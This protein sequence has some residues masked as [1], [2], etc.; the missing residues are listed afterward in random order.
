MTILAIYTPVTVARGEVV[1]NGENP[2]SNLLQVL[3]IRYPINFKKKSMSVL[4]DLG[5][6]VN[7]VHLIFAKE[8][9]LSIRSTG[10][11]AQKIYG[12][13]VDTYGMIVAAFSVI[14]KANQVKFF[15]ETFL[16]ANV[17]TK[18]VLKILFFTLTSVDVDFLD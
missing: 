16:V 18:I 1:E 11:G 8:L 9:G 10:V 17:S 3:C 2:R 15:E 7:I 6:K 14:D 4:L 13:M 12:T 5:S